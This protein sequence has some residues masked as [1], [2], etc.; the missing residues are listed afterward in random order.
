MMT[1]AMKM[2]GK[3]VNRKRKKVR[4]MRG[5]W[6]H[7]YGA[8]KKH[9]GKGSRGGRGYAGSHK[10]RYSYIVTKER[11]HFVHTKLKAKPK[12]KTINVGQLFGLIKNAD[13]KNQKELDLG[14]LGYGKLLGA[15][16][17]APELKGIK[18][19][20]DSIV[21]RAEEKLRDVGAI[22]E[23]K[24]ETTEEEPGE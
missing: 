6:T 10:H 14:E 8:K 17:P 11:D 18:I 5:L 7:G 22:V 16:K 19:K 13:K 12:P 15:G 4:K 21:P 9:R 2:L 1:K 23:A 24:T 3:R 20:V